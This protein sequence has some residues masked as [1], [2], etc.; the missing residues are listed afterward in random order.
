MIPEICESLD[1][2]PWNVVK[3]IVPSDGHCLFHSIA[4]SYYI[5]YRTNLLN[6]EPITRM[7]IITKLR[8]QLA[9][10]LTE[11]VYNMLN[12][13]N[14][15]LFAKEVPEFSMEFMKLE[16]NSDHQIGYGYIEY[17]SNQIDKDIYIIHGETNKIYISDELPFII[18]GRTVIVLYYHH[19][20]YEPVG[21]LNDQKIYD[22]H[23]T[24]SHPFIEFLD[25]QLKEYKLKLGQ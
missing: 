11:N 10:N 15:Q 5:P 19:N 3:F 1:F 2:P 20:H 12:D 13:G 25:L 4:F 17:I 6:N 18:K 24:H 14:T 16:L 9:D 21:V 8:S 7:E 23:F 22:T